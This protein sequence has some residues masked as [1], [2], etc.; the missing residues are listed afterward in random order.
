MGCAGSKQGVVASASLVFIVLPPAGLGCGG[1]L[2]ELRSPVTASRDLWTVPSLHPCILAGWQEWAG[3][4][5]GVF[6]VGLAAGLCTSPTGVLKPGPHPPC[7]GALCAGFVRWKICLVP[8]AA[9]AEEEGGR[10]MP[11]RAATHFPG[12]VRRV[13]TPGRGSRDQGKLLMSGRGEGRRGLQGPWA[14]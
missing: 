14:T 12:T 7:S 5:R 2:D 8:R 1:F 13:Q 4:V 6:V 9:L 3:W 10:M 11:C